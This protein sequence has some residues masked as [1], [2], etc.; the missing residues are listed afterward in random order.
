MLENKAMEECRDV[1]FAQIEAA[2]M[3]MV[4]EW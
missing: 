3:A 1:A 2:K 4:V